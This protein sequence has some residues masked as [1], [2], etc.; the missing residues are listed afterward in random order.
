MADFGLSSFI[1]DGEMLTKAVGTP[2]YIGTFVSLNCL[3]CNLAP[4]IIQTLDGDMDGYGSEVDLWSIGII[5]Y[6]L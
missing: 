2:G 4:E 6:I 3:T 5:M 1:E